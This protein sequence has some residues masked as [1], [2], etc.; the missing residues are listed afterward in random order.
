MQRILAFGLVSLMAACGGQKDE[1]EKKPQVTL[2][3]QEAQKI[4]DTLPQQAIIRVP[5]GADGK[6]DNSQVEM[7]LSDMTTDKVNQANINTVYEQAKLPEKIVNETDRSTS[8]A[9]N[10][11]WGCYSCRSGYG[12]GYA[13]S[14]RP[15]ISYSYGSYAWPSYRPIYF[16]GG[17][18]NYGSSYGYGNSYGSYYGGVATWGMTYNVGFYG[19]GY[20]GKSYN[21]HSYKR[22]AGYGWGNG[23]GYGYGDTK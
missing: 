6:E 8:Q 21:Y 10:R 2:T 3:E 5:I 14:Y 4:A 13:A 23:N 9:S 12:Y 18:A 7:R 15:V 17:Y 19:V 1:S 16:G 22:Y 20:A 11:G